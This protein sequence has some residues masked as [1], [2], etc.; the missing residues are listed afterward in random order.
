MATS[1]DIENHIQDL[2]SASYD[3]RTISDK[4]GKGELNDEWKGIV[5]HLRKANRVIGET[6]DKEIVSRVRSDQALGRLKERN[7]YS[8]PT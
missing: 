4:I 6:S 3:I 7:L 2:D 1:V 5:K 8:R